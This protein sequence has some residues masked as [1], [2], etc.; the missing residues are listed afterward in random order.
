LA[1]RG[2]H[3]RTT[4]PTRA[5]AAYAAMTD[6][7]FE[8]IN[9]RQAWAN[10]RTIPRAMSGRV[11]D[12]PLVVV[13]L[14]C[15]TGPSTQVLAFYAPFGS[16]IYGY[17]FAQPLVRAA[18]RRRYVLST[19]EAASVEFVCQSVTRTLRDPA[20]NTIAD[21]T[22]DLVNAS[23]IVGHHLTPTTG[24]PLF[25]ELGRIVRPGGVAMLDIG[26]T[27]CAR[28]LLRVMEA[29]G[30]SLVGHARSCFLDRCGELVFER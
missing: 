21:R 2:V 7:E 27:F 19:G 18:L 13:D 8:A 17:E 1:A 4:D 9:G 14:G 29:S 28:D 3:F 10:W 23:G 12:R 25:A 15:G 26:P 11:E 16:I 5:E 22:V 24:R 6:A 30:F 20:G